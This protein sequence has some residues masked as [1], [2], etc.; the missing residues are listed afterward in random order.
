MKGVNKILLIVI[1]ISLIFPDNQNSKYYYIDSI[2]EIKD[3]LSS[4][5]RWEVIFI[6]DGSND[7][8][9]DILKTIVGSNSKVSLIRFA[10]NFG[11]SDAL[12]E[13]FK[14]VSSPSRTIF[15]PNPKAFQLLLNSFL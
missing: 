15:L 9:H 8:S 1:F 4:Y 10:R 13:G 6:N 2:D 7:K 11:K 14:K 3:V 5:S 12:F